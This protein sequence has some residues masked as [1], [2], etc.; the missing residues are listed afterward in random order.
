MSDS[1]LSPFQASALQLLF[2]DGIGERGFYLSGGTALAEF[3]LHHRESDDLDLFTRRHDS[4]RPE[5]ERVIRLFEDRGLPVDRQ[6]V[7]DHFGRLFVTSP[8]GNEP[9][10]IEF[11]ED[12]GLRMQPPLREGEI[13]ID[14]LEDISVNKVCAVY[15]RLE[16]KDYVDL[17]FILAETSFTVEYLL[18]RAGDKVID[19]EQEDGQLIFAANLLRVEEFSAIT[20][21]MVRPIALVDLKNILSQAA[22][23]LLHRLGTAE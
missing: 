20:T 5:I 21:R 22:R 12:A 10:K 11:V 16:L 17:Y 8:T 6:V 9:L 14:S 7:N 18:E 13:V 2:D 1:I 19:L 3:Y 15:G 23:E 4:L